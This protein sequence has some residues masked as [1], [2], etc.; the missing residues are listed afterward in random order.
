MEYKH[1]MSVALSVL[2]KLK[3]IAQ[4]FEKISI[5]HY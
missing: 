5:C 1:I 3:E 2:G 4:N